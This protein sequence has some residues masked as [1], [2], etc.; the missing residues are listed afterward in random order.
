MGALFESIHRT[1]GDTLFYYA[2]SPLVKISILLFGFIMPLITYL[3]LAERKILGYMQARLGPNR[4]GPWGILQPIAQGPVSQGSAHEVPA[5]G[6]DDV[7][8]RAGACTGR[9]QFI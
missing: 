4:V 1:L 9:Q 6:E 7:G 5:E 2:F 8:L 3:V